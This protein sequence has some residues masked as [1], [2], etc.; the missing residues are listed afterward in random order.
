VDAGYR[1]PDTG[2]WKLNMSCLVIDVGTTHCRAAVVSEHGK[3]LSQ[4]RCPVRL[5]RYRPT[6]AEI[7][8]EEVWTL[9]QKVI[10]AE[11]DKHSGATL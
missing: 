1:V 4:S 11:V 7:D 6:F 3:I 5:Y 8:C 2:W 9:V 10:S